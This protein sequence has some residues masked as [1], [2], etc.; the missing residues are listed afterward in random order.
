MKLAQVTTVGKAVAGNNGFRFFVQFNADA[1]LVHTANE[2]LNS[3]ALSLGA[4]ESMS[5]VPKR[6]LLC[7]A[8][9]SVDNLWYR[10]R[11][12]RVA[13]KLVT[14]V[15][16]DFGNE[17]TIDTSIAGA[18]R[19]AGLPKALA[20]MRPLATE[21][22]LAYVQMPP[23]SD[24]RDVALDHMIRLIGEQDIHVSVVPGAP[25]PC[26][27]EDNHPVQSALVFLRRQPTTAGASSSTAVATSDLL[28]VGEELL[29]E[30][31]AYA[32]SLR[33]PADL[34]AKYFQAQEAAMSQR[35]NIWQYGDFRE[36]EDA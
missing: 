4:A 2:K 23:D 18:P 7:A 19:L 36:D 33:M 34:C 21:Y 32:E 6:G 15:F 12:T 28:D 5:F 26:G 17:E 29:R 11:V 27:K 31:L 30:G 16:I 25:T 24:Y 35:V 20:D 8:R 22:R 13:G 9:F 14:V 1:H 10:A 3:G